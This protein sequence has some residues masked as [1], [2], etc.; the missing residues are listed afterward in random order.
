VLADG[1]TVTIIASRRPRANRADVKC[2]VPNAPAIAE[3]MQQVV[4]LRATPKRGSIADQVVLS[5]DITPA[6]TERDWELAAVLADR[7]VRGL[8]PAPQPVLKAAPTPHL[9]RVTGTVDAAAHHAS[10]RATVM[11]TC[12]PPF[13]PSALVPAA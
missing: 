4:R 2:S 11:P 8:H 1:R 13:P 6:A 5:M 12:R 3:R 7:M 9:G 10:G